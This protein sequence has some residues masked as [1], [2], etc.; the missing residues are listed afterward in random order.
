MTVSRLDQ[1][2]RHIYNCDTHR[3]VNGSPSFPLENETRNGKEERKF[4]RE[5]ERKTLKRSIGNEW[6]EE[7][8]RKIANERGKESFAAEE[9]LL[10]KRE[11]E[12]ERKSQVIRKGDKEIIFFLSLCV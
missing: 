12:E 2:I 7:G 9:P 11:E 10:K 1:E 8:G 4:S 5:G 6:K 3:T